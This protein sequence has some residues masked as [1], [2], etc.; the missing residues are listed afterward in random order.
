[1]NE[2]KAP[3]VF[4]HRSAVPTRPTGSM[5]S[6]SVLLTAA[7]NIVK[8][9][10]GLTTSSTTTGTNN[11]STSG[12]S[13]SSGPSYAIVRFSLV[14]TEEFTAKA[15]GPVSKKVVD[16]LKRIPGTRYD[17][18]TKRVIFPL[19]AHDS[20]Q[21]RHLKMMIICLTLVQVALA[22]LRIGVEPL[23][24]STIAAAQM[25]NAKKKQLSTSPKDCDSILRGR[26]PDRLI[27]NLAEFQKEGV[28]FAYHNEGRVLI[29]DEMGLGEG[30]S[31]VTLMF[32]LFYREDSSGHRCGRD[33]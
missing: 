12:T 9:A 26:L 14:N 29:A 21:V 7:A 1:M 2:R 25:L 28:V 27:R 18:T 10:Q 30:Y 24:R 8:Q 3:P 32:I 17:P 15:D 33:V 23:V 4:S 20:L 11:G 16:V 5:P 6:G 19:E 31:L 13:R 22:S